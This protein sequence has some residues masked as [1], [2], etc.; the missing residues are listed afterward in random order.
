MP[1]RVDGGEGGSAKSGQARTR[2]GIGA[3]IT[4]KM[5]T[6]FM[7]WPQPYISNDNG[8]NNDGKQ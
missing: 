3:K 7:D 5:W 6:F 1:V 2:G 4:E 8:L